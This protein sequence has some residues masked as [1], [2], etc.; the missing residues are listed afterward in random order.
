MKKIDAREVRNKVRQRN[1]TTFKLL[2]ANK[3]FQKDLATLR[4]EAGKGW[5]RVFPITSFPATEESFMK[6]D[7]VSEKNKIL[8]EKY[9][10]PKNFN[11]VLYSYFAY[12]E[13]LESEIPDCNYGF[14]FKPHPLKVSAKV[15]TWEVHLVTYTQLDKEELE[16]AFRELL[17]YQKKAFPES[18][19][20]S[21]SKITPS[22][23]N[24]LLRIEELA[25]IR[26]RAKYTY[27]SL[28]LDVLSKEVEAGKLTE[29]KY[30]SIKKKYLKGHQD[31]TFISDAY[32][33]KDISEK[34]YEAGYNKSSN[35]VRQALIRL[36]KEQKS[37]FPN[38]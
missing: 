11:R 22:S 8:L 24:E 4:L 18:K 14:A 36:K 26:E 31:A 25:K 19:N 20:F 2:C 28:Y 6:S 9:S 23:I 33:S 16:L 32:T 17:R 7:L 35:T 30:L 13:I 12:G 3:S 15:R 1:T 29:T 34:L 5:D 38:S 10:L 21:I 37:R 27:D